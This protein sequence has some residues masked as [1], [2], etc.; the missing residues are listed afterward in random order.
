MDKIALIDFCGTVA[1]F[2]TLN[3]YLLYLLKVT[4][5]LVYKLL[6]HRLIEKIC[7]YVSLKLRRLGYEGWLYRQLLIKATSGISRET[8][9]KAGHCYYEC[10]VKHHL[11]G[12]PLRIIKSLAAQGYQIIIVSGGSDFYI[13]W[14][15]RQYG[16]RHCITAKIAMKHAKSTGRIAR[17]CYGIDKIRE[18]ETYVAGHHINGIYELGMTDSSSDLAMLRLCRKKI[19]VSHGKKQSW[20]TADMEEII[21]D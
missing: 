15:C 6:R 17:E 5:P 9:E 10:C 2:Q 11:L 7:D 4:K 1:D 18:I 13:R 19:V 21:W 12:E 20:V 14:F 16:I 8:F 3:P